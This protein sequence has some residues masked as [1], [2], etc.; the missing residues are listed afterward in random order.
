MNY[1]YKYKIRLYEVKM[2]WYVA[3]TS[4]MAGELT[5][6]VC[7]ISARHQFRGDWSCSELIPQCLIKAHI[8]TASPLNHS[9]SVV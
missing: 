9:S 2:I 6:T 5:I 7:E 4:K 1:C 3:Q 8:T